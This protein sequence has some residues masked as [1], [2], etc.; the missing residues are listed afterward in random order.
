MTKSNGWNNINRLKLLKGI[1]EWIKTN[2]KSKIVAWWNCPKNHAWNFT[3]KFVNFKLLKFD[4]DGNKLFPSIK[5]TKMWWGMTLRGPDLV[6][7]QNY[8][9]LSDLKS[10]KLTR[11]I[12]NESVFDHSEVKKS[13]SE[14]LEGL[15]SALTSVWD[16]S[17][18]VWRCPTYVE[19]HLGQKVEN[20]W[21][22]RVKTGPKIV[23]FWV[24]KTKIWFKIRLKLY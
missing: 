10:W 1:G 20:I 15:K 6:W 9:F 3:G 18:G 2:K 22:G 13:L 4:W 19:G 16:W 17:P 21:L 7:R 11:K 5:M 14:C 24:K 12:E 23:P 8:H